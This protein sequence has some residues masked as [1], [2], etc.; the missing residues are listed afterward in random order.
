[1]CA[2]AP[3]LQIIGRTGSSNHSYHK[4][5]IHC[6]FVLSSHVTRLCSLSH[7]LLPG[8]EWLLLHTECINTACQG[9]LTLR[10]AL[11]L[12]PAHRPG[13]LGAQ[14]LLS[15][16]ER[17]PG[18]CSA[19]AARQSYHSRMPACSNTDKYHIKHPQKHHPCASKCIARIVFSQNPTSAAAASALE[20][21]SSCNHYALLTLLARA[22]EVD[23]LLLMVEAS[24]AARYV[25]LSICWTP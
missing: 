9:R 17:S 6:S 16:A 20:H 14:P 3:E 19:P 24:T 12:N 22:A 10:A 11:L 8:A 2:N 4:Q 5:A 25:S 7:L 15:D 18:V 21:W 1:M 13:L 23:A